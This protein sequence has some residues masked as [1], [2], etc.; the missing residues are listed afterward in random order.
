MI[1]LNKKFQSAHATT[2]I[3]LHEPI[4]TVVHRNNNQ[5]VANFYAMYRGV[6]PGIRYLIDEILTY[7]PYQT[8]S[9]LPPEEQKI[10]VGKCLAYW[11]TID[12][13][14]VTETLIFGDTSED[15]DDGYATKFIQCAMGEC[16]AE[17]LF[18]SLLTNAIENLKE[19]LNN[20]FYEVVADNKAE[21]DYLKRRK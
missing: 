11:A 14:F 7:T 13:G 21:D 20:Y 16:S 9:S 17:D 6:E 18:K 4:K 1:N 2:E 3:K 12:H 5:S 15:A 8:F 10:F 19:K